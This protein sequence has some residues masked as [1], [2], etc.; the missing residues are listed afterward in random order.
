[1]TC[2]NSG[3]MELD[4]LPP[5]WR[6]VAQEVLQLSL[7]LQFGTTKPDSE[8]TEREKIAIECYQNSYNR[9]RNTIN[10]GH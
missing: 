8:L 9:K 4:P 1:M 3:R 7:R 6:H 2:F 10:Q 5:E